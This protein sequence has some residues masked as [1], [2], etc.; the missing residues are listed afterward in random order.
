M[1]AM[2]KE[3]EKNHAEYWRKCGAITPEQVLAIYLPEHKSM[4]ACSDEDVQSVDK[5]NC[6]RCIALTILERSKPDREEDEWI[7]NI[8]GPLVK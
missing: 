7:T 4:N 2:A 6:Y 8:L 1:Y 3:V 5:M